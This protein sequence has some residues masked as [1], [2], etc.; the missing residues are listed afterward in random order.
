MTYEIIPSEFNS[1]PKEIDDEAHNLCLEPVIK[2][3]KVILNPLT[4]NGDIDL[5][6]RITLFWCLGIKH[7]ISKI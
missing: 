5:Q 6:S 7:Q 4:K 2:K 3:D 1:T